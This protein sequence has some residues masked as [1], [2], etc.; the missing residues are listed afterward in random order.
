TGRDNDLHSLQ[1]ALGGLEDGRVYYVVN[2][3]LTD[4][5]KPA[6]TI[7]LS[8]TRGGTPITLDSSH[9][10]GPHDFGLET[11]DL[12]TPS[13]TLAA[14]VPGGVTTSLAAASAI[15]ATNIKVS[16]VSGFVVGQSITIDVGGI[17]EHAEITSVGTAGAAGTGI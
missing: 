15:G 6:N 10:A 17:A 1:R 11:V 3:Y 14:A 13:T 16:S 12:E 4:N 7:Q 8:L 2:S 9:R 5:T